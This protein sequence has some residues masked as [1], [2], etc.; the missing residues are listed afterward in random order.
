M[1]GNDFMTLSPVEVSLG[2]EDLLVHPDVEGRPA[3]LSGRVD[4]AFFCEG[5]E[6]RCDCN[7]HGMEA[8][9][10]HKREDATAHLKIVRVGM[11]THKRC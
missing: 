6:V 4:R 8:S 1:Y 7:I 2:C 10:Y 9:M 5:L 3:V 11:C